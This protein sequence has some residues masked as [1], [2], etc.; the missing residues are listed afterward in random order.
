MAVY[1]KVTISYP[2]GH[3]EEIE[4]EFTSLQKAIDFGEKYLAQVYGTEQFRGNALD[5][6]NFFHK[7]KPYFIV[8][9]HGEGES[10]IVFDSRKD[11]K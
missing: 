5:E 6:H 8:D 7:K 9:S 2:D 10:K 1:Y 3:L 4:E 11:K